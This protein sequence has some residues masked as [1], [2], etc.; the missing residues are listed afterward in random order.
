MMPHI[1]IAAKEN[2]YNTYDSYGEICVHC[3]CCSE[4]EIERAKARV[5]LADRMIEEY[6]RQLSNA[7]DTI[8]YFV[9]EKRK[10]MEIL[11]KGENA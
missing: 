9:E 3:G 2:C 8:S 6:T 4:D 5:A 11:E 10:N 1:S 7:S